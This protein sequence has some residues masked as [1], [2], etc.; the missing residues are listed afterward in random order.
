MM[1]INLQLEGLALLI[2]GCCFW[3][4]QE[5]SWWL[6]AALFLLPDIGMLGYLANTRI[7]AFTYNLFHHLGI[8]I[9]VM[10]I[11]FLSELEVLQIAGIVLLAHAGFDRMLGYGLK[12]PDAFKHTHLDSV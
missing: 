6:F 12:Y 9:L 10:I 8:A 5:H 7:G 2:L 1:K 11:G 3:H 4:L